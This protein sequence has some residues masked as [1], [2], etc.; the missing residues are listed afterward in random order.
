MLA[1]IIE[2]EVE[3]QAVKDFQNKTISEKVTSS[4]ID[5]VPLDDHN[6]RDLGEKVARSWSILPMP[7]M[8][9]EEKQNHSGPEG[10]SSREGRLSEGD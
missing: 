6:T 4:D 8:E 7:M 2:G 9:E 10:G 3:D 1:P 5:Q